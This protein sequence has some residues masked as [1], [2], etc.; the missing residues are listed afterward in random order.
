MPV[1]SKEGLEYAADLCYLCVG[2]SLMSRA[3][4]CTCV[5]GTAGWGQKWQK[6]SLKGHNTRQNLGYCYKPKS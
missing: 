6:L 1:S 5:T 3:A 2:C 4:A